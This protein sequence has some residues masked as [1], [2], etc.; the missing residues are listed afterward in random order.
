MVTVKESKM[1]DHDFLLIVMIVIWPARLFTKPAI[2][3]KDEW[4]KIG[5]N[6]SVSTIRRRLR[7]A[8][9]T[10]RVAR[11]EPHLTIAH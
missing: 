11:K 1:V 9:L 5:Y 7:F 3:L 2:K 6:A 8:N 4:E 10:G